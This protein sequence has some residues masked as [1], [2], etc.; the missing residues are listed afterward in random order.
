MATLLDLL[1]ARFERD[2]ALTIL[3]DVDARAR[4]IATLADDLE[5]S[6]MPPN[7]LASSEGENLFVAVL[8]LRLKFPQNEAREKVALNISMRE[9][10]AASP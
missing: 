6:G 4:A 5:A 10:R 1:F 2:E 3:R 7:L 9:R 8:A